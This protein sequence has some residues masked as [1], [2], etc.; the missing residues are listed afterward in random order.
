MGATV[1][2]TGFVGPLSWNGD[3]RPI[4]GDPTFL[5]TPGA[6]PAP[7]HRREGGQG[8]DG[9]SVEADGHKN[10]GGR[11]SGTTGTGFTTG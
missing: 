2:I 10:Q 1:S 11:V 8:C 5:H 3:G 6:L 9:G 7:L 4:S